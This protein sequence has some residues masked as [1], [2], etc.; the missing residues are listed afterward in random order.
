MTNLTKIYGTNPAAEEGGIDLHVGGDAYITVKRAGNR[1]RAFQETFRR[2]TSPY[3][4]AIERGQLD[5]ETD[6]RLGIA[7]YAETIAIGWRGVGLVDGEDLPFSKENFI[8]VMTALPDLW[9]VVREGARDAANFR[10]AE[11]A[12][13]GK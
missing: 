6:D 10:D 8:R 1:N 2:I 11:V 13:A 9:R 3:T 4:K 5:G 12:E 7:I